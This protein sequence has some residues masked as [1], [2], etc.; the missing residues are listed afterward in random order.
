MNILFDEE[1]LNLELIKYTNFNNIT[2][3][4]TSLNRLILDYS[5]DILL[6]P[7]K[8]ENIIISNDGNF[9]L[10][11]PNYQKPLKFNIWFSKTSIEPEK[12][13]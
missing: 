2:D 10:V 8:I 6:P 12:P 1:Y 11:V 5:M 9:G 13:I 7:D 4:K 3:L